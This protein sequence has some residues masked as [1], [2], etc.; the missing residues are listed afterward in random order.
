MLGVGYRPNT[1]HHMVDVNWCALL[2]VRTE[3]YPVRLTDGRIVEG[4]TWSW[5]AASCPFTDGQRYVAEM[6]RRG[7]H[8][9][10]W[11]GGCHAILYRLQDCY[12]VIAE[13][14]GNGRDGFPPCQDCPIRP[15][16]VAQTVDS[17]WDQEHQNLAAGSTAWTY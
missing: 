3:A 9:E 2:G 11:I 12:G 5:R 6:E 17:D 1:F 16:V 13:M 15:R 8:S 10:V 7:L 14:L 4:R